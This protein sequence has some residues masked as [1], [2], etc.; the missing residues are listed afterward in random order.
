MRRERLNRSATG[1]GFSK[2]RRVLSLRSLADTFRGM[3]EG[4]RGTIRI[5]TRQFF[6]GP[7]LRGYPDFTIL[8]PN[9]SMINGGKVFDRYPRID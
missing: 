6:Q 7:L 4:G 8:P 3:N 1:P 2:R 5:W 9:D